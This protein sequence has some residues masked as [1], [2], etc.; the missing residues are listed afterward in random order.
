MKRDIKDS[1][2]LWCHPAGCYNKLWNLPGESSL[3]PQEVAAAFGI[4]K[5]LMVTFK[6]EPKPPFG[7]YADRFKG[8]RE[9]IWSIIG[10]AGSKRN[11]A[12]SDLPHVLKLKHVLP[13]LRGGIM[14]DFF[15][16]EERA[17]INRVKAYSKAL[18]DADLELWVVVYGHQLDSPRLPEFLEYCDVISFWTWRAEEL[19]LL[20]ERLERLRKM[21][22]GKK[23]ALGCYL[24]DFG[25]SKPISEENMAFQCRQA[26]EQWRAGKISEVILL[27]SPL[28]GMDIEAVRWAERWVKTSLGDPSR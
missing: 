12:E 9:V 22:P 17:D 19:P 1:L 16:S 23:I 20:E 10:D 26:L 13:N 28:Y 14:D 8:M 2:W 7:A 25:D 21:A 5:A 4:D 27:G 6:D 11:D 3:E 15:S 18:R 24:W